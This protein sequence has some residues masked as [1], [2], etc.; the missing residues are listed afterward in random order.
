[1]TGIVPVM[2]QGSLATY[3]GSELVIQEIRPRNSYPSSV[4][5]VF[6]SLSLLLQIS[7]YLYKRIRCRK[8]ENMNNNYMQSLKTIMGKMNML[9]Y[10]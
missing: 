4:F 3:F 1:M 6:F 8:F 10:V 5:P 2:T 7:L 9:N